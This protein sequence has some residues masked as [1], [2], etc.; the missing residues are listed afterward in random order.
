[1][2]AAASP[3]VLGHS[4]AELRRLTTQARLIDPITRRFLISAGVVEGMRVLDIGSGAGDVAMLVAAMVGPK[5][6]V[7][8][9]DTS[10]TAIQAAERRVQADG[11][12]NI[13][14]RHGDPA[15]MAFDTPFDA[16][17]GRYVLQFMDD[18][19]TAL[20][21]LAGHLG[22]G[23]LIVFH[24]LD[25][26]G[27][28]SV[29]CV[30]TYDRACGWV[31]RTIELGGAQ[32]RI[33][34]KLGSLFAKA[35]LPPARMQIESVIAA[36]AAAADV[37][38]LVVDLVETLMPTTERLGVATAEEVAIATLADRIV[39]EVGMDSALIGRAE[40]AAWTRV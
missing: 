14:F 1:M 11:I 7:V 28:R 31:S 22:P 24:E 38:H 15:G 23:G 32:V 16:V 35:G 5:G 12:A 27:A 17:V 30:P 37:I 18:P 3:Y 25:W 8:G 29:P 36:G 26:D 21:K 6:E 4:E 20:A 2:A 40:V 33:G 10:M 9:T 13:T 19:A 39:D 34:P